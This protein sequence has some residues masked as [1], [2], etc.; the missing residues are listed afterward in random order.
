[1]YKY[2]KWQNNIKIFSIDS[3]KVKMIKICCIVCD[4]CRKFKN[5]KTSYI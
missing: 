4:K 5:P 1:M 2:A 3:K